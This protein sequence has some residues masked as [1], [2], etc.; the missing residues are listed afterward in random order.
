MENIEQ[1]VKTV[2]GDNAGIYEDLKDAIAKLTNTVTIGAREQGVK[3]LGIMAMQPKIKNAEDYIALGVLGTALKRKDEEVDGE[4]P[5]SDDDALFLYAATS[6]GGVQSVALAYAVLKDTGDN[7]E[8]EYFDMDVFESEEEVV[9]LINDLKNAVDFFKF[10]IG[11][12]I[13]RL[14]TALPEEKERVLIATKQL[15]ALLRTR[16]QEWDASKLQEI[17]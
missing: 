7:P 3:N 14:E 2:Y 15:T 16:E 10:T 11:A 17:K 4:K 8:V 13:A 5:V 6:L 12:S 1:L 9:E